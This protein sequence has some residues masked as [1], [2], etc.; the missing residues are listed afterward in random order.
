H[1]LATIAVC[2]A[3]ALANKDPKY[4]DCAQKAIDYIVAA[5]HNEGGWRYGFKEKGDTSVVGWQIMALKSG[6]MAGLKVPERTMKVAERYVDSVCSY[7][8]NARYSGDEGYGYM[9]RG[10]GVTTTAIGLLCREYLQ[11]W[12]D[13]NPRM[14]RGVENWI[15]KNMPG[16]LKNMYYF[17]YATQ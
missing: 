7:D 10:S 16:Q 13:R 12:G 17:Y 11:G 14:Q 5:Q 3:Y 15:M 8:E 6:Q 2:E 4:K 1:G 9:G